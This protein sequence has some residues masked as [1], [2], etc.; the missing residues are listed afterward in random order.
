ME[1]RRSQNDEISKRM[2]K[3]VET[4][5]RKIRVGKTKRR[6]K[7]RERRKEIRG[8]RTKK[9][10]KQKTKKEKNNKSEKI[11]EKWKIW[12]KGEKTAARLEEEA[13]RMVLKQFY[14]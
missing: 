8:E 1:N 4:K 5:T 2:W 9:E 11:A 6:E 14:K 7:K 3:V 13:K 12:N 10:R